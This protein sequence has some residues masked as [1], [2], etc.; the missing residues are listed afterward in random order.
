MTAGDLVHVVADGADWG[1]GIIVEK[2]EP[3][4]GHRV[5]LSDGKMLYFHAFEMHRIDVCKCPV[6]QATC[7]IMQIR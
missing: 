7:A 1:L 6:E 5:M 2:E 3:Y 4:S